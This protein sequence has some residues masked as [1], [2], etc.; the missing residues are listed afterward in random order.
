MR[1]TDKTVTPGRDEVINFNIKEFISLCLHKWYWIA[2]CVAF[3]IGISLFY[4]YKKQ[5]EYKRYEQILVNERDGN[6]GISDITESFSTLGLFSNNTNVYNELLAI[7]SPAVMYQVAD[8]LQ[9]DMNYTRKRGMRGQTL[10]GS[11]LPFK[12]EMLDIDN[13]G[14]GN[15]KVKVEADGSKTLYKFSK[16]EIDKLIKYKDEIK[17][18]P[19]TD[20]VSTPLGRVRFSPNSRYNGS[21]D[22]KDIEINVSKMAMQNTVELYGQKL[23]GD[24]ADE[25]ADVIELSIEDVSVERANDILNYILVVYNQD[26]IADKNK[27]A[28]A[29]SKF[30][31]ERLKIIEEELGDVDQ[32]IAAYMK[33]T[34]SPDLEATTEANIK[35]GSKMEENLIETS[36]EL[37]VA[38]YMK[39][40]LKDN[41]NINSVLPTNLGISG[42]N[43]SSQITA[44]NDLLLSRNNIL[45]N[46]SASN[47]LVQNY[48]EQLR[49]M[50]YAIERSVDNRIKNLQQ[51][52]SHLKGEIGKVNASMANVPEIGL[53]LLSEERQR[54]IKQNLYLYLLQ[55]REENELTQ[56]FNSDNVRIITPPVGPLRPVSP[57]KGLIIVFAFVIGFGCPVL[58]LYY[59]ETTNTKIRN[60]KDL[61]TLEIPFA[62]EIPQV[63]GK[64]DIKKLLERTPLKRNKDDQ[65]PLAVVEEGSRDVV[66]EAF[67]V[68]RGNVDFMSG[69]PSGSQVIMLTSFNPGSGKSF[70]TYNLAM[71]YCLKGRKV[72]IVDCDLR[73]G[74]ASMYVGKPNKGL[75]SYLTGSTNDWQSLV[76]T[77]KTN[78]NLNI[79][80]IGKIPPN[81]AEL[82]E[83][84]RLKDLIEE[85]KK[86]YDIIFLDCPPVNIVVDAQLVAPL[87]DR[88]LFVVRAGLLE[89]AAITEL[90]SFYAEKKFNNMS[91]IL[92]GT[93]Q[94]HSRYYTY[95]TYQKHSYYFS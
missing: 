74:S 5:P 50:H 86:E 18:A 2:I 72:L 73:H 30:I 8:S 77:T 43:L 66:N 71:S 65:A 85:A 83:G 16:F 60:K 63:G 19:G 52:V 90:N 69:K 78:P 26:W 44:Y 15:F 27:I 84:D 57:K 95:G 56:K 53:P 82:L 33:K 49:Q 81:P 29:T 48:D 36:N 22:G 94:V 39:D 24:L 32:V 38:Q 46:S 20:L 59:L 37:S 64:A 23:K 40:F 9:L 55:K 7:T 11:T 47:P 51:S 21:L 70:I 68:I 42:D 41:N 12:V 35:L 4:I 87:A 54:S 25:D 28:V 17:V 3:A 75:T 13:Q 88:T 62:G 31:D 10:Y 34:G 67:R 93:E 6:G 80:P 58:I 79:M 61:E 91:V 92:N 1:D 89:K 14:N 76:V 45:A